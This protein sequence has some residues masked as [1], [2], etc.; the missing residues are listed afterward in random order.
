MKRDCTIA[1]VGEKT[2]PSTVG[3]EVEKI[4]HDWTEGRRG[5]F[6][7]GY[8][9]GDEEGGGIAGEAGTREGQGHNKVIIGSFLS[10]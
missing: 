7:G 4:P 3:R 1:I 8:G 2:Q 6:W 9:D 10:I 5:D